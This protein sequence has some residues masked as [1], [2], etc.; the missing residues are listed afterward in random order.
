MEFSRHLFSPGAFWFLIIV[1]GLFLLTAIWSAPWRR[2]IDSG[3]A[4]SF[5]AAVVIMM[6]LW[7]M[8]TD[9]T[10]GLQFHLL[11]VTSLTLMFGWSLGIIGSVLAM[12]GV[13]LAGWAEWRGLPL[14]FITLS[15]IPVTLTYLVLITVRS[16]L[17]KHFFVYVFINAFVTGGLVAIICGYLSATLLVM[18]GAYTFS[19]LQDTVMPFF[20]IMFFPEA[21]FNGWVMTLLIV[22]KP[23]WVYSFS[24]KEYLDG[25]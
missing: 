17:P 9:V 21:V 8:R 7:S 1:C 4:H 10:D 13:A 5:F 2:V 25:K 18:S 15:L 22:Y 23:D 11:G 19:E 14:S 24:D 6:L 12:V 20:P 3:R 16:F